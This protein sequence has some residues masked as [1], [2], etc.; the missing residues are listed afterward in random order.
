LS[1]A[2]PG[3]TILR[4]SGAEHL[5]LRFH[6]IESFSPGFA[7]ATHAHL[8]EALEFARRHAR[9]AL[10]VHCHAGISRSPAVALAIQVDRTGDVEAS[11]EW[12]Y[13]RR[14]KAVPNLHVLRRA[15]EALGLGGA[16]VDAV[17]GRE[18]VDR[19]CAL[20]R[21]IALELRSARGAGKCAASS[22]KGR[23]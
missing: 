8:A 23:A 16:L 17:L 3:E 1:I 13:G 4:V 21:A 12:L 9:G 20:R 15:G 2:D 18:E 6:D 7:E 10:L 19:R 14:P 11:V 22:A 5:A